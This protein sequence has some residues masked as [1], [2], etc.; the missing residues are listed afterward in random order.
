MGYCVS[1]VHLA[2]LAFKNS[3]HL[4]WGITDWKNI[5][6]GG[7]KNRLLNN[8]CCCCTQLCLILSDP[9]YY[10]PP[11]S[12]VNGILT[13]WLQLIIRNEICGGKKRLC[14]CLLMVG[15]FPVNNG[16]I[17]NLIFSGCFS[18]QFF[19][20]FPVKMRFSCIGEGKS[21]YKYKNI[22]DGFLCSLK[23]DEHFSCFIFTPAIKF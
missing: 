18:S 23:Y 10:S 5:C 22:L 12:S 11:G 1:G 14:L 16:I 17:I 8:I 2:L 15:P 19:F 21:C 13:I 7:K 20:F 4:L 9:M 3:K 6:N